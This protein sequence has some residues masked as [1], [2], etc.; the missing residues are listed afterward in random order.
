[1]YVLELQRIGLG[2]QIV[3][4]CAEHGGGLRNVAIY[5]SKQADPGNCRYS[6]RD[7]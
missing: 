6:R 3:Q 2:L 1:M 7:T 4:E 5:T